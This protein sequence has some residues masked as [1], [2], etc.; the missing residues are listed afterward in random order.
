MSNPAE[1]RVEADLAAPSFKAGVA[2]N[3]WRVV[4]YTFPILLA[5]I[6]STEPDGSLSWYCFRFDLAA[7]PGQSPEVRIW[8]PDTNVP[9]P[10]Q[11]RPRG[12]PR[13]EK[14]VQQW[15][16]DT[17]YRPWDRKAAVH[18]NFREKHPQLAWHAKRDLTFAFEDLYGLLNINARLCG[19]RSAA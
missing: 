16:D 9:L 10:V 2:R 12:N 13:I 18:N 5:E 17:V 3:S 15:G 14:T 4:S 19:A 7:Y 1:V 8:N 6:A 11:C